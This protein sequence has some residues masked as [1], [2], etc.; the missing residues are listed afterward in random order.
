MKF[1]SFELDDSIYWGKLQGGY[2]YY[3]E[4]LMTHF[5]TLLVAIENFRYWEIEDE[6]TESVALSEV[7]VVAPFIPKKNVMCI[8]KNYREHALEMSEGDPGAIPDEPVIFTKSPTS[9]IGCGESIELNSSITK[10]LDYEGELAVVIGRKGK[11]ISRD[12]AMEHVFGFTIINDVTAR[13]LQKKHK[14]FFRGKSLDTFCPMG[15]V[16]V[17]R[18]AIPDVQNLS[19]R[20]IVNGEERQN[21]STKDMI[22]SVDEL[23]E[24]L[25]DGMTLEPGDV[26]A[27]GTPSGV[28][29]GF[30][31]PKFL[32]SGDEVRISIES[33]GE[34]VNKVE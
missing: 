24:V 9:V 19:V 22:F 27:T 6:L 1:I 18:D 30:N 16:I 7:R 26:I 29:K 32:K 8:G 2:I 23:I 3:S 20:T 14:Q 13:D 11:N 25:S 31:P 28:G 10:Q 21:G 33:I 17:H 15:P 12:Q 34:L 4:R 5:P